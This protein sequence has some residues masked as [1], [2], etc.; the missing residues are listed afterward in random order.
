[1]TESGLS[2]RE[3]LKQQDRWLLA[4]AVCLMLIGL[5][6]I[7][8]AASGFTGKGTTYV[9]RQLVSIGVA[10]VAFSIVVAVGYERAFKGAYIYYGITIF[11]LFLTLIFAQRTSG[12]KRWLMLG[13]WGIQVS[14]YTKIT[15]SLAI[16]KYLSRNPADTLGG[17]F[18]ALLVGAPA[19]LLVLIQPDLGS[20]IVLAAILF[21]ALFISGTPRKYLLYTLGSGL[22]FLPSAWIFLKEYQKNRLLVFID[23]GVDP[24][25]A[26]YNVIQ[27]RIAVGSGGLWGKGFLEG[28]QSKLRFLPEAHTDFIFSVYSEEFGFVGALVVLLLFAFLFYRIILAGI[29]SRDVRAK[30]LA[31][32]ISGWI[33]FQMFESIGMSMGLMP[34][35]GLTL[36]LFSYGGSSLLS[37][38]VAIGLISSVHS[39]NVKIY[40]LS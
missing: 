39:S 8:S 14:E 35:T 20:A 36:P 12:S 16:S 9:I 32:C 38:L 6:S 25:G 7:F 15:L 10:L 2:A 5:V 24:L 31:G 28:M 22:V 37:I 4:A 17:Y 30:I 21:I 34:V 40:E 29:R 3:N 18:G 1:M 26:G 19:I 11:L 23:P 13:N 27:S 33:W